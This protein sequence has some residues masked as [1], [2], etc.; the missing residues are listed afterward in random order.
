MN[1]GNDVRSFRAR[2]SHA[3]GHP[4]LRFPAGCPPACGLLVSPSQLGWHAL[5]HYG[6]R[7]WTLGYKVNPPEPNAARTPHPAP[8]R[9]LSLDTS[10]TTLATADSRLHDRSSSERPYPHAPRQP[11][12]ASGNT[13]TSHEPANPHSR[14]LQAIISPL[15]RRSAALAHCGAILLPRGHD[16]GIPLENSLTVSL[17]S[18]GQ[19]TYDYVSKATPLSLG[20]QPAIRSRRDAGAVNSR[21]CSEGH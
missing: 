2:R 14:P 6:I 5:L 10:A 7:L 8:A 9:H 16:F 3:S 18:F 20:H 13:G 17:S 15:D 4:T 1:D 11:Q 12:A 21:S 19:H